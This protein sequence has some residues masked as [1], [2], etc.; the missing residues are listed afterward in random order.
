[1][2]MKVMETNCLILRSLRATD[3]DAIVAQIG[4][5]NVSKNLA[6]VPYPYTLEDANWFF[7]WIKGFDDKSLFLA[8][9]E[10]QNVDQLIGV[11]SYEYLIEK[12]DAELG[13][14]LAE[15]F[16]RKGYMKEAAQA[17]V[18]YGFEVSDLNQMVS[19]FFN[20]NPNSGRVLHSVGFE[21]TD[22]C[23]AFSKA[24]GIE[25]PVTNT[26]LSRARWLQTKSRE[27]HSRPLIRNV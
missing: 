15:P 7:G 1:M 17:V 25:V 16:W 14:W 11:I 10:K 21:N 20:D 5:Y 27:D 26:K 9:T 6:R 3:A 4:N 18:D 8:I 2:K 22:S 13:Y 19:C 12:D 23:S 24:Q